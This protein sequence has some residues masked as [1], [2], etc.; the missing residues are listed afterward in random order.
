MEVWGVP[1]FKFNTKPDAQGHVFPRDVKINFGDL[2]PLIVEFDYHRKIG[3][4]VLKRK[5][6]GIYADLHFLDIDIEQTFEKL[7]PAIGG[8]IAKKTDD[9]VIKEFSIKSVSLGTLRNSNKDIKTI[10]EML[11]G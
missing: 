9:G 4:A 1:V 8:M 2:I 6:D 10:G 11:D 5:D 7:I 3:T